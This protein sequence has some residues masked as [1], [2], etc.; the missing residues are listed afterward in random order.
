MPPTAEAKPL[1]SLPP[2]LALARV[3]S[4]LFFIV[5]CGRSGTTLL[6]SMLLSHPDMVIPPETKFYGAFVERPRRLPPSFREDH[7]L[8]KAAHAVWDD[9]RRRGIET[10]EDTLYRMAFAARRDPNGLLLALL[11]A[12]AIEHRAERVGEKSP[13]H[14]HYVGELAEAF[15]TAKFIHI[16]RDPRAVMLSRMTAGFGTSL[17][18]PNIRRWKRAAQMHADFADALGPSRYLLVRY[19]D[20]VTSPRATLEKVC[21]LIKLDLL[22]EMLEPHK[23]QKKGFAERSSHGMNKPLKPI[24][25][26]SLEKWKAALKPAHIAL[27]EHA[28]GEEMQRFGYKPTGARVALPGLR[29]ALSNAAGFL[30]DNWALGMRGVKKLLR[31]GKPAETMGEGE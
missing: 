17:I 29:L 1:A 16:M 6:Q 13:I 2:S 5:G 8:R 20:L 12:Y 27:T 25:T 3:E 18:G 14:T 10:N 26:S 22:P 19:E 7:E 24:S 30:E 28:L 11:T 31:G 9:Q 15:P 4:Q 21:G 23:R